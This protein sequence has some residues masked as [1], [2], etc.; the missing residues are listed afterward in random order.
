MIGCQRVEGYKFQTIFFE[1]WMKQG[2]LSLPSEESRLKNKLIIKVVTG[3]SSSAHCKI[4]EV[5]IGS[6]KHDF[7]ADRAIIFLTSLM[8]NSLK[9]EKRTLLPLITSSK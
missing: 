7:F 6:N 2:L 1:H 5:G 8:D 4:I 9:S 3:S